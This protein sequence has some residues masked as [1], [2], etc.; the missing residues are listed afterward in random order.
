MGPGTVPMAAPPDRGD[1]A[2]PLLTVVLI[3]RNQAWNVDRLVESVLMETGGISSAEIVLVDSDSSDDTIQVAKRHP[4]AILRLQSTRFRTA[5]AGRSI[6]YSQTTGRLVLFL[7]GDMELCRDWLRTA[8]DVMQDSPAVAGVTG[9]VVDLPKAATVHDKPL[10]TGIG[11]NPPRDIRAAGG[12]ALYRRSVLERVGTF[13]PFLYSEEEP[14]LCLRIRQAGY[15]VVQ[16]DSPIA[17]HYTDRSG[18]LS[19]LAPRWRRNLYLGS[20][21]ILRLHFGSSV[22]WPYIKERGYF[23]A[24]MVAVATGAAGLAGSLLSHTWAGLGL[25][26]LL[27]ASVVGTVS[28]R[29]Q[30]RPYQMAYSIANRVFVLIGTVRGLFLPR[31][32]P[33]GHPGTVE[34]IRSL[35]SVRSGATAMGSERS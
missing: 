16:L 2:R 33:G 15:R 13:N 8:L 18:A 5:A 4:I 29:R 23:V 28:Y 3:T 32:D 1:A 26:T 22:F 9:V 17:F 25:W 10:L 21:Q 14:E 31:P 11:T 20:G 24:P 12:A 34:V 19:T 35:S 7:D 30:L 6:G 27:V